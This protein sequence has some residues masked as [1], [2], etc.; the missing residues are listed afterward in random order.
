MS[1]MT[2]TAAPPMT[3]ADLR[4]ATSNFTENGRPMTASEVA[5]LVSEEIGRNRAYDTSTV[6]KW[7]VNGIDKESVITALA[8]IYR[9]PRDVVA[10]AARHSA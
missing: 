2:L 5:K 7:E 9:Q 4:A 10:A 3:L 8:K 1:N 6:L